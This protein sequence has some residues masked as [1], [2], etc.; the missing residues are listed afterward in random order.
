MGTH[1]HRELEKAIGDSESVLDV[2]CG[3]HSPL[4]HIKGKFHSVGV[5]AFLP[6]I[7]QSRKQQIHNEYLQI[8]VL[9]INKKFEAGA[10]DC[11]IALDLIEHLTKEDGIKLLG[12]M[13]LVAKKKVIVFTPNDFLPQPAVDGNPFQE[14]K[15]GWS[16]SEMR[17][18]NYHVIG[19]N[20]WKPLR[21]ENADIRFTPKRFWQFVSKVTQKYVRNRPEKAFQLL[22]VKEK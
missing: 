18:K 21:G 19:I 10:F 6:S 5:D 1:Y 7:E 15:S 9:D 13:E 14:H 3:S 4:Q 11:V 22:C 16:A 12:A 2:G 8:D 17:D 20:G